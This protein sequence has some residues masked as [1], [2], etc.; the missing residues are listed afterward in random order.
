MC[1]ITLKPCVDCPQVNNSFRV[2]FLGWG[3]RRGK[4]GSIMIFSLHRK[5][6]CR[7][8]DRPT[9]GSGE[10]R[11]MVYESA[12]RKISCKEFKITEWSPPRVL[13]NKCSCCIFVSSPSCCFVIFITWLRI[14]I[15][16]MVILLDVSLVYDSLLRQIMMG[17]FM[18]CRGWPSDGRLVFLQN[19]G[20]ICCHWTRFCND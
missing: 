5:H 7:V 4:P 12:T 10:K 11:I 3:T 6:A 14:Q 16:S 20:I 15:T 8:D 9:L 2:E 19:H 13:N 17:V 18:K 1:K